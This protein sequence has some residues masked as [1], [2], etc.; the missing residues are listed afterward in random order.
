MVLEEILRDVSDYREFMTV[1]E[2]NTSSQRLADEHDHVGFFRIGEST[3][4]EPISALK[5]GEGSRN[6]LLFG[7]PHPNEPIGSMTLEYL[8]GRLAEDDGLREELGYTWYIVKCIDP[9]GARLNEG[10]FKGEFTPLKYVLNYYR[11]PSKNQVE[12]TFPID[13]KT[14]HFHTPLPETRALMNLIEKHEPSFMYSLHNAGFCGVYWYLGEEMPT[15]YPRLKE[16]VHGQG[17]PLHK[18]EPETPYIEKL[19]D[20]IF[21]MVGAE[22]DYD[23]TAKHTDVDP[24]TL[25]ESG[26]S[27]HGYLRSVCGGFTLVCEMPYYFD[28]RVTD[29]SPSD[30]GRREAVLNGFGYAE[31]VY[32]FLRPRFDAIAEKADES[33]RLYQSVSDYLANFEKRMEPRRRHAETAKEYEGSATV[34]Q[35]FDSLV[36]SRFGTMFMMGMAMRVADEALCRGPDAGIQGIRDEIRERMLETNREVEE[37]SDIE[38]IPIQKLVRVQLGSGLMIAEHLKNL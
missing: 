2:L 38:V 31:E 12:W 21:R 19:D 26:T 24:A 27:S 7:F 20:A 33:K 14:L 18:G 16:L 4:G 36:A 35:A 11:P 34:A 8:S 25:R 28:Q 29:D 32:E 5:I 10:W 9:D 30:V 23:F 22:E 13:Y 3:E 37:A 15:L 6:A 17:L 1:D